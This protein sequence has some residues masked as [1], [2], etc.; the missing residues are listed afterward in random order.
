[1]SKNGREGES[2]Q[3]CLRLHFKFRRLR[4]LFGGLGGFGGL[5]A[6]SCSRVVVV[7]SQSIS[8]SVSQLV[9]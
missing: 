4:R 3:K 1:M 5:E 2:D 8:L 7:V 9:S 6:D